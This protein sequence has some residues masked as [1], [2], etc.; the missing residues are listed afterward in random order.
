VTTTLKNLH[1]VKSVARKRLVETAIDCNHESV[2][3][4]EL[5]SVVSSGV[6][7]NPFTNRYPLYSHAPLI[8]DNIVVLNCH[9]YGKFK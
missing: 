1:S 6:S 8:R 9:D 3:V 7:T 5:Y 4:S 2:C